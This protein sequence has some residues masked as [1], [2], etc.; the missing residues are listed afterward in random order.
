MLIKVV[1]YVYI[2]RYTEGKMG[3]NTGS[4]NK[5]EVII[6]LSVEER[7]ELLAKLLLDTVADESQKEE[8]AREV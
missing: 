4:L 1:N 8:Y 7:M 5:Q 6:E 2:G 3:R